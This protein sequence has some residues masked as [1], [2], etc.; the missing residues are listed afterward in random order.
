MLSLPWYHM[1][2]LSQGLLGGGRPWTG[3]CTGLFSL[4]LPRITLQVTHHSSR[5]LPMSCWVLHPVVQDSTLGQHGPRHF[6]RQD[7]CK[8]MYHDQCL[9][10]NFSFLLL[11][12]YKYM[13][14]NSATSSRVLSAGDITCP[15]CFNYQFCSTHTPTEAGGKRLTPQTKSELLQLPQFQAVQLLTLLHTLNFTQRLLRALT[16]TPPC[17]E[18]FA[19][20]SAPALT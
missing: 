3:V 11:P 18:P 2:S 19:W 13:V 9:H 1:I 15:L 4:Q 12:T 10:Q 5:L 6:E 14:R 7:N 8:V 17:M 16:V 20:A